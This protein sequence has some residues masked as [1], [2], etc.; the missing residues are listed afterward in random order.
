ML[1]HLILIFLSFL[2]FS[3][4]LLAIEDKHL[5]EDLIEWKDWVLEEV[6]EKECPIHYQENIPVCSWYTHTK[7][8]LSK[9]ELNFTMKVQLYKE[10][11]HVLLPF[12]HQSWA[13]NVRVNGE[14]AVVIGT[15]TKPM[16][17]LEKGSYE[18]T[19]SIP[20]RE[21]LKYIQLPKS[22]ALVEL[23][24][25]GVKVENPKID[26]HARLWLDNDATSKEGEGSVVVSLYRKLMDG[27]PLRM[28]THLHFRI[29]GEMRSITLDGVLLEGFLPLGVKSKLNVTIT[30][31]KSLKVEVKAG[32]WTASIDSYHPRLISKLQIPKYTFPYANEE[33]WSLQSNASYRTIEIAGITSIDPAQTTLPDAW[34]ALPKN[35]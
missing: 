27:H 34:K 31:K 7:V 23:E 25:E 19:G 28:Q 6:E 5:P 15:S 11:N 24:K 35:Q 8:S 4:T 16:V 17:I 30:E 9:E 26:A 3:Q 10:K 32:E 20:M 13:K 12:S 18:I 29:S 1:K 2:F 22:L 21:E 14:K 33:V